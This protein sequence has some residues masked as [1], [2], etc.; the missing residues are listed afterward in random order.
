LEREEYNTVGQ[1]FPDF[2]DKLE[3]SIFEFSFNIAL[4][5]V[6][7]RRD[8]ISVYEFEEVV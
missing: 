6:N 7:L 4:K 3:N 8:F 5:M 1:V 2:I